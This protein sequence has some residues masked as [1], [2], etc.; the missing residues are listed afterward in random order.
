MKTFTLKSRQVSQAACWCAALLCLLTLPAAA[1]IRMINGRPVGMPDMPPGDSSSPSSSSSGSKEAGGTWLPAEL[2]ATSLTST[3]ADATKTNAVDEIQLSFQGANVDMIIQ[4]LAQTTG[5]TVL[6]HPQVQCQLTITS[7]KKMTTREAI[8][9]VYR[10]LALEKVSVIESARSI[11]VVPEGQEPRMS[12]EIAT[13]STTNLL[14]GRQKLVKVFTLQHLQAADLRDRI[15]IALTDKA[16]IDVDERA[17][18]LIITD[19]NDNIRIVGEL[20]AALDT[21]KPD[22]VAVRM[23]PLKNVAAMQLARE[24]GPLYQKMSGK[25]LDVAADER[26]NALIVLSSAASFEA[27]QKLVASLD[28]EDAMEKTSETFILKNADA[29]DVARQLQELNQ[30]STVQARYF[31]S[32]SG[33]DTPQKKVSV[34]ADRRRNAV[35][36]QAPPGQMDRI[37]DMIKQLDAPVADDSLAPK[38]YQLKYVSAV[39]IED[40]L[41]ELFL[42]KQ[43]QRSYY[44][45]IFGDDS[46][47]GSTADKDVGRLYGKVRITSEPYSNTLIITS[48]SKENLAV[49]EDVLEQLDR[50]SEAGES[51]MRIGL[52]YAKASVVANSLNILFA[53]NGSPAIRGSSQPNPNQGGGNQSQ[54]QQQNQNATSSTGFN[55]EQ[56]AKED[57]YFPWLGGQPDNVRSGD[58]ASTRAVSDLVGRVRTVADERGNSVLISANVHYFPQILKLIGELDAATD[59]V[60]IEAR[61]VEVS[62]DYLDKLGVRWSPDGSKVFSTED[63][64]N[65]LMVRGTANYQKGFNGKTTVNTPLSPF[66]AQGDAVSQALASLRSGVVAGSVNMDFLVQFLKKNTDASVIGSPQITIND[67]E[68]GKLFVGQQVPV[69]DTTQVSS[70]G[71]Q[72]TSIKYKDVGVVL[73]VTPHINNSGDVHLKIHAESSSVSP[74]QTVLGGA[75]F[76][77][78]NFRTDLTTKDGQT[79]ILGGIIQRQTSDI[80]RRTPI[81][82]YIPIIEWAFKKQDKSQ[83][84]VELMV[85][86]RTKVVRTP[87]EAEELL[88]D[89]DRKAP[90]LK[91]Y[92][93]ELLPK[94]KK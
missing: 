49:V 7:S 59:Q 38:I 11:L 16:L 65:S 29:Q 30:T 70:V 33:S 78:R 57:G 60:S 73:E 64:E 53:K 48:N 83:H 71:S 46:G 2:P 75:V 86:L 81:L 3:N 45:Y 35:I 56:Q 6:K 88:K 47:G 9:L 12:P 76:D 67:N 22:D 63:Y 5:K 32:Y 51:T 93:D 21:D 36:V 19:Y 58:R 68:T 13:G 14:E 10:A 40:V 26:A 34:V 41:N 28:T 1:Q 80:Q 31:Y 62:T 37:R 77:T 87:E 42:K 55:L 24:I 18:Q 50:P 15:R 52:K 89:V 94:L 85:F 23:L 74:G 17:N 92:Q 79:L 43:Q 54:N 20:I 72:N 39:D 44:D 4:W 61:I 8:V 84:Q 91:K 27:I 82:G 66:N 90:Q 25:S 69:P